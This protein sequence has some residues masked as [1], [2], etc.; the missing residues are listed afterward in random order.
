[1]PE[2]INRIV[3]DEF[4][5]LLFIHCEEASENL[6]REGIASERVHFVGN[7]MIDTLVRM[8]RGFETLDA[9]AALGLTRRYLLVTL[10]RP[11]LVDGPGCAEVLG[12]SRHVFAVGFRSCSPSTRAR[13]RMEAVEARAAASGCSIRSAISTSSRSGRRR[14][15][16]TDSGGVQE[17]TTFLGI[18]CFTMRNNTERPVTV[19]RARTGCSAP[20]RLPSRRSPT[21]SPT[22][23]RR[24]SRSLAGTGTPPSARRRCSSPGSAGASPT[25]RQPTG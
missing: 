6:R 11:A 22:G 15:V 14:T 18:P 13:G 12:A 24:R 23:R 2:E 5:R 1:M 4:S 17:E 25:T 9:A 19:E 10:H 16:L 21:C 3:A 20:I 7:T 8:R